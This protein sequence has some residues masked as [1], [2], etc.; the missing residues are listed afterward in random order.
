ML[1]CY[2]KAKARGKQAKALHM[3][4]SVNRAWLILPK[5]FR[6]LIESISMRVQRSIKKHLIEKLVPGM[7]VGFS[8]V[9]NEK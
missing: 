8:D 7:C 4:H 5:V 1:G 6:T 9:S 3:F 2:E